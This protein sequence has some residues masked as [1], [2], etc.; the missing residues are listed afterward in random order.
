MLE[1]IAEALGI[2]APALFATTNIPSSGDSISQ[3]QKQVLYDIS[4]V[5]S[6][7]VKELEEKYKNNN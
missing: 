7:R 6:Y 3:F 1:R 2:D 4:Q 5:V